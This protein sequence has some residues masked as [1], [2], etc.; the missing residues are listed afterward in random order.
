MNRKDAGFTLIELLVVISIVAVLLAVGM[1]AFTDALARV[2]VSSA[3]HMLSA[4]M[5]MARSTAVMRHEA[6]VICPLDANGR[7]SSLKDWSAG[8]AVFR[9]PDGNRAPDGQGRVLRVT[10]PPTGSKLSLPATRPLLRY[11]P[12]GRAAH[13][14][15]TIHVCAGELQA[16]KVVV[17]NLGR[18][19]SERPARRPCPRS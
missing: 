15:L 9:D 2:R 1:P 8:W 17:N 18:V 10:D 12:D 11:Q 13:S 16:G 4:D 19:R 6:V 5:A 3:L 14:N 7:C